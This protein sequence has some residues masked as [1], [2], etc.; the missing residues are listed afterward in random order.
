MVESNEKKIAIV[1][2]L[3]ITIVL[4]SLLF[5][6]GCFK[7]EFV[8][9]E[10]DKQEIYEEI[11]F[12]KDLE[13]NDINNT[14]VN[15]SP[16]VYNDTYNH[17]PNPPI[18]ELNEIYNIEVGD[19]NFKLP[20]INEIDENGN[21]LLVIISYYFKGVHENN[22][23]LVDSFSVNEIGIYKVNYQ[24]T[25]SY[26]QTVS[27]SILI[28][29]TDSTNPTIEGYIEEYEP[30][31]GLISYTPVSSNST[32]NKPLKISF[33]DIWETPPKV[34]VKITNGTDTTL[35]VKDQ[36]LEGDVVNKID[37]ILLT[38]SE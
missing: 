2:S 35:T 6:K 34:S 1:V 8:D 24:V 20:V 14:I 36:K 32:I 18:L 11:E 16:V 33:Y 12:D 7:K 9:D 27:Q 3:L 21:Q 29:I 22:F 4:G 28:E 31:T 5:Y 23:K 19:N 30:L 15:V 38:T 10:N 17:I 26:N 13:F 37:A 25:D